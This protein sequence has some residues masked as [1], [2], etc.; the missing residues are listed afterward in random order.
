MTN[1]TE[2]KDM[3]LCLEVCRRAAEAC[4]DCASDDAHRDSAALA[5]CRSLCLDSAD[6]CRT[7]AAVLE[8]GSAQHPRFC[9]LCAQICRECAAECAKHA[10][11]HEHCQV[12]ENACIAC[13]DECAR[14][15]VEL[16]S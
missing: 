11:G 6:I 10:A 14:H 3:Q 2:K 8:R 5:R 13:A 12:C 1:P 7:T 4:D 15:A 9:A 16:V